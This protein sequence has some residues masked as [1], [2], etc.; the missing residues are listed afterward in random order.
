[1]KKILTFLCSFLLCVNV[2]LAASSATTTITG[3]PSGLN[4][5]KIACT[6]HTDGSFTDYTTTEPV[7]GFIVAVITDPGSTAPTDNY[8]IDLDDKYGVDVMGSE[9]DNRD[10]ANT[11][12]AVPLV[13]SAY[14]R[15]YVQGPLTVQVSNNS[16]N[17]AT[18][19]IYVLIE[20]E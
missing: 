7:N 4:I 6:A 12:Q 3:T 1:M 8:D 18:W 16:V 13:G 14:S 9:L 10:T 2:A 17:G 5:M 20:K 11:E 19:D 15:R